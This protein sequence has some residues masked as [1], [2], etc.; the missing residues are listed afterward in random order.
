MPGE[1]SEWLKV[2][3]SK[4]GV[5]LCV[6]VGSNPTLSAFFK[7]SSTG[8]ETFDSSTSNFPLLWEIVAFS[9]SRSD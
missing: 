2:P 9:G 5:A 1:V 8:G 4:T 6:T 3:V 7:R